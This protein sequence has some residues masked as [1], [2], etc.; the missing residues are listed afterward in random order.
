[1]IEKMKNLQILPNSLAIWAL[2]QMGF[3]I[4][5]S[6]AVIYID[7]YLS[8][9]IRDIL[10]DDGKRLFPPPVPPAAITNADY[11]LITH[12]HAD[13]LD[14][15]TILGVLKGSPNVK[16]I[17]SGWCVE[18]LLKIGVPTTSITTIESSLTFA[19]HDLKLTAVPA[20][21]YDLIFD[22]QKGYRWL[23]FLIEWNGIT[24]YHSGDTLIYP[25][26]LDTLRRLPQ[27][28]VAILPINGRDFVREHQYDIIGNLQPVEAAYLA[29]ELNWDMVILGHN[30][31]LAVNCLPW[32]QV[33]EAFT[34][35]AP[36]HKFR[37]M[38]PGELY[39]Y[40]KM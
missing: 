36:Y 3:A 4:Q 29:R 23:G 22:E 35:A 39:Y 34:T 37:V 15:E 18:I 38:Q 24:I 10:G 8:D 26:Y 40:V 17:T 2:G 11:Y 7:P 28:D 13:H 20:A 14:A 31:L 25:G 32:G 16:F 6:N 27:I 1:M 21:H 9:A 33:I 19:D 30:D 5:G 12:E